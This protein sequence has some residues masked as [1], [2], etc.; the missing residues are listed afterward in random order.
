MFVRVLDESVLVP[1]PLYISNAS[2]ALNFSI[3]ISDNPDI[4]AL[5]SSDLQQKT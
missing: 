1:K 2:S 3:G 4:E 5:V